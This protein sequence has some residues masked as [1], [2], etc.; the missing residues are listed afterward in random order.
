MHVSNV[1]KKPWISE[2]ATDLA[3]K[4]GT[5]MFL[6]ELGANR[7]MVKKAVEVAYGV[8]VT[9][10]RT[11]RTVYGKKRQKKAFVTLKEGEKIDI[12]PH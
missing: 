4:E 5:Y 9:D 8:H 12:L 2:K 3:T 6:V 1:I 10:V 7:H 11:V